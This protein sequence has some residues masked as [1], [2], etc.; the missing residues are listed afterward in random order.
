MNMRK[1]LKQAEEMQAKVQR[2]LGET[3]TEATVGGGMVTVKMNGHKH[4]LAVKIDPEAIDPEDVGM[5]EDLIVAAVNEAS[6]KI[7]DLLR[8]RVGSLAASLP[9]F[10]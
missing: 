5:L 10:L 8:H 7:D 6:R 2:E 4:L 3:F 9:N 1:L